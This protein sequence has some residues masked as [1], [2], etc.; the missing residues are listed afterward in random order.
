MLIFLVFSDPVQ[1]IGGLCPMGLMPLATVKEFV[2][3]TLYYILW[4]N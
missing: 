2:T 3:H 1:I 4:L